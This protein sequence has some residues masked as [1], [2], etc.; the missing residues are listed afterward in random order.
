FTVSTP[1]GKVDVLG[2]QF[3]VKNRGQLFSVSCFEGK[4][5]VNFNNKEYTLAKGNTFTSIANHVTL[6]KTKATNPSWTAHKS[7]FT[8]VP[9]KYVLGELQ[10]QYN[11]NITATT[12]D[13][14]A[15]FT[16]S[17]TH[18]DLETALRAV[19][20]PFNA[21]YTIKNGKVQLLK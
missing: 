14:N 19:T 3:N 13:K 16:G 9:L 1:L 20:L 12:L 10:R 7:Y 11:I 21:T 2:T 15:I 17:F 5:K 4:V 6:S 8:Q 18:R